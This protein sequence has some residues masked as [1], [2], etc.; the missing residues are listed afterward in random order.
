MKRNG[1]HSFFFLIHIRLKLYRDGEEETPQVPFDFPT[2]S[3]QCFSFHSDFVLRRVNTQETLNINIPTVRT[4]PIP[5]IHIVLRCEGYSQ[6]RKLVLSSPRKSQHRFSSLPSSFVSLSHTPSILVR[7][8][9][10][11]VTD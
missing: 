8:I 10:N 7:N 3:Q 2:R 9:I 4:V 5:I 1:K 11:I 6:T